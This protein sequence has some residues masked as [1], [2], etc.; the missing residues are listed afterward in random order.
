MKGADT[1]MK[2]FV[3]ENKVIIKE[4]LCIMVY[5]YLILFLF[6]EGVYR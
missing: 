5:L 1:I 6:L 3:P 2:Q 4:I